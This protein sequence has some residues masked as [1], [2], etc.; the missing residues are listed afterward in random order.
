VSDVDLERDEQPPDAGGVSAAAAAPER[1]ALEV[2]AE[3]TA[4]PADS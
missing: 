1:S 4:E 3:S 2:D